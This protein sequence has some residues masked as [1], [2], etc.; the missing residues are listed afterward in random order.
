MKF[1]FRIF[2]FILMSHFIKGMSFI[3]KS[4]LKCHGNL[5]SSNCLVDTKWVIKLSNFG[6]EEFKFGTEDNLTKE[7]KCQSQSRQK[8]VL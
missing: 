7:Q 1:T 2:H 6:L 8:F 4:E 5:K 3:Q